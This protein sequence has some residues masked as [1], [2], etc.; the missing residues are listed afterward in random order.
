MGSQV[1]KIPHCG[2]RRRSCKETPLSGQLVQMDGVRTL[3]G[4]RMRTR[5]RSDSNTFSDSVDDRYSA[6][7][8]G[9]QMYADGSRW[10]DMEK[11]S[12][13]EEGGYRPPAVRFAR[14]SRVALV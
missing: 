7:V 9:G 1:P 6:G 3:V 8:Q 4:N 14:H 10:Q 5:C 13:Q 12:A 2:K 11:K